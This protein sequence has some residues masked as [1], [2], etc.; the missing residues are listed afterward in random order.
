MLLYLEPR[1]LRES[2]KKESKERAREK[3]KLFHTCMQSKIKI[4]NKL[5]DNKKKTQKQTGKDPKPLIPN[6]WRV[7]GTG[8][9]GR[10]RSK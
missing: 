1:K 6:T 3:R 8:R 4:P 10:E 5:Q 2:K 9:R 7:K